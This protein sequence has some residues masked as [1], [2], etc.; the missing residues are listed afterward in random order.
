M[1]LDKYPK[2]GQTP[3]ARLHY[4]LCLISLHKKGDEATTYLESIVADFP[5]SQEAKDAA[6]ELKHLASKAAKAAKI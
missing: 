6:A 1:V 4:A 2:S 5:K 3:G